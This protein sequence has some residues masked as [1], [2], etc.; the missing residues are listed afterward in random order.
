MTPTAPIMRNLFQDNP[1]LSIL[2]AAA[3]GLLAG[4]LL[5][6]FYFRERI[7]VMEQRL[8]DYA[9]RRGAVKALEVK[10]VVCPVCLSKAMHRSNKRSVGV[11]FGRFIGRVPYRCERCFNVSLHWSKLTYSVSKRLDT[12]DNLAAERKKFA[13]ELRLAR[14]MR[15]L[16]PDMFETR[17]RMKHP[18]HRS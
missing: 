4:L 18:E 8:A 6:L 15:R 7:W 9:E 11:L 16:Y 14:K 3:G 13:D 17:T 1:A 10:A 5:A 12:R 2:I